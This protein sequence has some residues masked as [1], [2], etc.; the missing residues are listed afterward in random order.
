MSNRIL[1]LAAATLLAATASAQFCSD[2]TY[3]LHIVDADGNKLPVAFDPTINSNAALV[4]TEDVYLA[5]DPATPTGTYY[6]HVTDAVF[7]GFDEVVSR[8]DPMDRF[9]HIE[10]TAGVITLTFPFSS[11]PANV[12]L[13]EGLNGT[14]QS[15]MLNPFRAAQDTQCRFKVWCGDVW[16]LNQGPENPYMIAGGIN[17]MTGGCAVRSYTKFIIGDGSGSDISGLVFNDA[18]SNGMQDEGEDGLEGWTVNLVDGSTTVSVLT[19]VDGFYTFDNIGAASL[20]V[21][22]VV[23]SGFNV[24]TSSNHAIET[25]ACAPK[26]GGDFGVVQASMNCEARTIGYWRNRHGR[27]LVQQHNIL[28]MLP[29]LCIVNMCGQYVAPSNICQYTGWLQCANSWNMAYMLSAQLVA[30][31]NNV[32]VGYVDANCVINDPCLGIM[33]IESLMQQAV[34][35]LCA[36]P[37]TPPCNSH[38]AHQQKLKNALDSANNNLIWQFAPQPT[39]SGSCSGQSPKSTSFWRKKRRCGRHH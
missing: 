34:A 38:R 4:P 17:P 15:L 27:N 13:G 26:H 23:Q 2:N 9:V 20:T 6:V 37:F 32:V 39:N 8:N 30:M 28:P 7:N 25:C 3:P 31:H 18:N 14:G 12:A 36:H 11:N 16:N 5:F 24:T 35:S 1:A 19:D 10:N 29:A 22:L 33:T 21:E